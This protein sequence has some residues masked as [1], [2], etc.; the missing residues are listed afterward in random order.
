MTYKL[1]AMKGN[2]FRVAV[3]LRPLP[4]VFYRP[5]EGTI[6]IISFKR[7]QILS[8]VMFKPSTVGLIYFLISTIV[9]FGGFRFSLRIRF[10]L[11]YLDLKN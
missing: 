8:F 9:G 5:D 4:M 6:G 1:K 10:N 3:A 11:S 7:S 2:H